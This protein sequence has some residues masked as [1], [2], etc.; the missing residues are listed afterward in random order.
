MV[1]IKTEDDRI[2]V[3]TGKNSWEKRTNF[4]CKCLF[5]VVSEKESGYVIEVTRWQPGGGG[6]TG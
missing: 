2:Y 4:S 1:E 3:K 5:Q 6:P